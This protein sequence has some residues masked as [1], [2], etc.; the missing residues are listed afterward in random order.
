MKKLSVNK[1]YIILLTLFFQTFYLD[2]FAG[3]YISISS[4]DVTG[5]YYP[6]AGAICRF[7]N[8]GKKDHGIRCAAESTGGSVFNINTIRNGTA[9]FGLSQSDW[10]YHA[11]N[12]TGFFSN[13]KPFRELRSVFSLYTEAFVVAV[14]NDSNIRTIDDIVGKKINMGPKASGTHATME[15]LLKLKGLSDKDFANVTYLTLSEQPRALC[16]GKVDVIVYA[17]GNPNPVIEEASQDCKIRIL[18]IDKKTIDKLVA[19]N[20]FYVKAIVPGGMYANNPNNI[21]TFGVKATLLTSEKTSIDI[22][23]NLTKAVFDNFDNFKTLHPV[24]STLKKEEMVK[25][26]N[27]APLHPGAVKYFKEAGLL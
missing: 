15:D 7:V 13:Q 27:Y 12:G 10:Q 3:K 5:V 26:G 19:N 16:Q 20:P 22:V 2:A 8:R 1:F 21:E 11:Y 23:Y 17:A 6:T 25:Q 24:F 14:K 9:T 18:N 4:G